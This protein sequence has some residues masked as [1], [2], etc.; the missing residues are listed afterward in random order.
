MNEYSKLAKNIIKNIGG[1]GN[2]KDLTHCVT[3][4]RF[5]L[6]DEKKANDKS[7]EQLD[8]V[9]TVM[10]SAG[11]YQVVIGNTVSDV[12]DA[13]MDELGSNFSSKESDINE[14][15]HKLSI[16]DTIIDW[17]TAIFMP[18]I[19]V[20]CASGMI[21]GLNAIFQNI[22]LY[23]QTSGIY[24]LINAI[25][26][27]IFFFFPIILGYNTAK[28]V[29]IDPYI[30]MIIGASLCYPEI[31]G[32]NLNILGLN[33]NVSYTSTVL[34]VILTVILAAPLYKFLKKRIPEAI[35]SFVTPMIVLLVSVLI[36]FIV[37][38]PIANS[39]SVAIS[40]FMLSI[41][42]VSPILAGLL[43]GALWQIMVV[44]GVHM[45]FIALAIVNMSQGV[46]DP[47]LS[48]QVFVAFAQSAVVLAIYLRTKNQKLKSIALPSFISGIFGVTEPAIYGITLPRMKMFIISCIG[49]MLSGGYA[50]FTGLKYH[51]MAGLGLF[52]IPALFPKTGS[53]TPVLIQSGIATL[54]AI[55]PSFLLAFF[56]YKEQL[57]DEL[58]EQK[59]ND[60]IKVS[61]N[62]AK[63]EKVSS[64]VA[65]EV[66]PL[67]EIS[68]PAFASGVLGKGFA[69]HP[70][71][72]KVFAPFDGT[73]MTVFP[74]KHAIGL[75]SENGCELLIHIGIDTVQ[76]K[77]EYYDAK[78]SQGD[79]ITK[80]QLL[81]TFDI[82]AIK[83]AG[84]SLETSVI[85]TNYGDYQNI[86]INNKG[87]ENHSL[88][89]DIL[90]LS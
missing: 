27:S 50:A 37:I 3:R 82:E 6:Y 26:D 1:S 66:F 73:V 4:L 5:H 75:L 56:L 60:F 7:I 33:M 54:I 48:L 29:K 72:G 21:K 43:F 84:Y 58:I 14:K 34:P 90:V 76:L 18:S 65:G 77:G 51:M 42:G 62:K 25:G 70:T 67:N 9:L 17:I 15:P 87:Q 12:Y 71:E 24:T 61:N 85:V 79:K 30:G 23:T 63:S 53:I 31:N 40:K 74:T 28:K 20:L 88:G 19:S 22:G 64:P 49:G 36:G 52:E 81:L 8:G 38:G 16:K 39:I 10:H 45:A 68:D 78:V 11:Q 47:I 2:I 41:Y 55:V 89:T 44:F 46:P 69:V 57:E 59:N 32:K 86:S 35:N 83:Q 80:G 13:V